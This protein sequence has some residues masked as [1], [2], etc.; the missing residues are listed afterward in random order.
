MTEHESIL[1]LLPW[2]NSDGNPCFLSTDDNDGFMSRLADAAEREQ[3]D[4]GADVLEMVK[5]V[6]AN[7]QTDRR[8][9]RSA[10]THAA[11][12]LGDVLRVAE[13]RGAR[14][15]TPEFENG[16]PQQPAETFG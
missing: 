16:G 8:E 13:S 2:T 4:L 15:P 11:E 5:A 14:L 7:P 12:A 1:R 3:T 6:L 10:L 9:L